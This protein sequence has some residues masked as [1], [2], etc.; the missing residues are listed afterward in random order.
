M[1]AVSLE[2]LTFDPYDIRITRRGRGKRCEVYLDGRLVV[3]MRTNGGFPT[4]S[5]FGGASV[6]AYTD[7]DGVL[8]STPWVMNPSDVRMRLGGT[9]I[10][11]GD[12]PV[13]E[14]M[15]SLGLPLRAL[16]TSQIGLLRMTFEDAQEIR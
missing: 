8:R 15:R 2:P 1:T 9:S 6:A 14:Q 13:A 3:A 11:L 10:E 4:L 16:V 12:H 7:L 5:R